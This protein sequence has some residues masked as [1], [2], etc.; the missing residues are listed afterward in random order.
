MSLP[1]EG[2]P[3]AVRLLVDSDNSFGHCVLLG[4]NFLTSAR[5]ELDFGRR[6]MS[7]V[8]G[9][10]AMSSD[11]AFES[12]ATGLTLVTSSQDC[13]DSE[14][15]PPPDSRERVPDVASVREHQRQD[16]LLRELTCH[17]RQKLPE[18]E[19]SKELQHFGKH[20][21][22]LTVSNDLLMYCH[23]KHGEIPV[24]SKLWLPELVTTA[25]Q[26]MAHIGRDKLFNLIVSQVF[27]PGLNKVV[28]DIVRSCRQ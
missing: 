13:S 1:G 12:T 6:L 11:C 5:V 22:D 16:R 14:D 24:I 4:A 25:H 27:C 18:L 21:N 8:Y 7:S 26:G 15:A 23:S 2:D 3:Q 9:K 28:D 17:V 19:L 10:H 20:L